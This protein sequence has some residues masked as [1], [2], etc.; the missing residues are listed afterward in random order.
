[1][2]FINRCMSSKTFKHN[3][4]S[5]RK[6]QK[7]TQYSSKTIANYITSVK[8]GSNIS[9]YFSIDFKIWV[10]IPVYNFAKFLNRSFE[11]VNRQSYTKFKLVVIDD[12]SDDNSSKIIE[13][14]SKKFDSMHVITNKTNKGPGFTKWQAIQYVSKRAD[15]ND[16]FTILDGD[17]AYSSN[18]TLETIINAYLITNCWMTHG[19]ADGIFSKRTFRLNE[20]DIN[21]MRKN[22]GFNF[23]H[24]RSCLCFLLEYMKETDF[25]DDAGKWLMRVTDRMFVFKLLELSG[26]KNVCNIKES[27]YFYRE[28]EDNVRNKVPKDYKKNIIKYISTTQPA[29]RIEERINIVMCCYKRHNNLKEIVKAIDNQTVSKR[30][31]LHI[32]NTNP[33][34]GKWEFM[35]NLVKSGVNKNI[36]L[37]ICNTNKNLYGYAR[38]LYVKHLLKTE[39]LSYVMFIDDDQKLAAGWVEKMY[40]TRKPLTYNCWF[41]R[42]FKIYDDVAKF[43][44]WDSVLSYSNEF[45]NVKYDSMKELHYGGTCGCVIDANIFR[46]NAVFHCPNEYRNIEDLWL[47]YVV[48]Q[49]VGG[50]INLIREPIKM[51]QF[52]NEGE[53]ALWKTIGERKSVF[54]RLLIECGYIKTK[55]FNKDKLG[56]LIE[57]KDDSQK[58][59]DNFT[60]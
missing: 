5:G 10:F 6:T 51:H 7:N 55:G 20:D 24:P 58:L 48:K 27:I 56:G 29:K 9:K 13:D 39:Y 40:A 37:K 31:T 45:K 59:I 57:E 54:L 17:D 36:E 53:T 15:K 25:Q 38:F 60:F 28:H 8:Q 47:S 33:E 34:V 35:Q 11:S 50:K 30:I 1:M 14:W 46:F 22:E 43:G 19:S 23:Q 18:R 44:Y 4:T 16:V 42:V 49:I 26:E 52:D 2:F 21:N 12:G 41:G 3:K 32:I